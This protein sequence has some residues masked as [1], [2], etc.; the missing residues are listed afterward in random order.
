MHT[1]RGDHSTPWTD[2]SADLAEVLARIDRQ[3]DLDPSRA[4]EA[5]DEAIDIAQQRGDDISLAWALHHRGRGRL[6]FGSIDQALADQV[7]AHELFADAGDELGMGRSMAF[8]AAPFDMIGDVATGQDGVYHA[9]VLVSAQNHAGEI[10]DYDIGR[11][12]MP[13]AR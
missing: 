5:A 9:H 13:G 1:V 7:R 8:M 3:I 6:T 12:A 11:F 10:R 2:D 4:I